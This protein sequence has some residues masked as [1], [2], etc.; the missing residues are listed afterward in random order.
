MKNTIKMA[1]AAA[2]AGFAVS[3][4]RR[5]RTRNETSGARAE[6]RNR[7]RAVT[8]N[9]PVDEVAPNGSLPRPLA[10]LSDWVEV[11]ITPAADAKGT[12]IAARLRYPEPSGPGAVPSR[13]AGTDP[14]QAV[15]SALRESKQLIEVGEVLRVE[16]QPAGDRTPT[17]AGKILDAV[18]R[19]AGAEGVY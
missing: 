13:L 14:R 17:P 15:R 8:V 1:A 7:W 18:T 10:S 9:K 11:R 16:P 6:P 19:R 3:Q 2:G 12:E 5:S 4:I